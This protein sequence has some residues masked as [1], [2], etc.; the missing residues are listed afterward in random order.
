MRTTTAQ[1][2]DARRPPA[3]LPRALVMIVLTVFAAILAW[4][5]ASQLG[6]VAT[7]LVIAWFIAL[8]ME[9]PVRWLARRGM[10]RGL[11]TGL[12]MFGTILASL[13]I[14]TVFGQLFVAQ[15]VD[16]IQAVPQ[17]YGQ[18]TD[19]VLNAFGYE[20]PTTDK[21]LVQ[22]VE[23]WGSN[24]AEGVIGV[25]GT[26]LGALFV[27]SA[28]LLVVFYMVAQGP[29]FKAS[30]LSLLAP[31]RQREVLRV[32][33]A[34]QEQVSNFLSSRIL[35]AA[36]SALV[37]FVYLTVAHVPYAV[38]LAAFSGIVSQ[39]IPTIGTYIGGALPVIV[40]L[41]V[42]PLTGLGVVIF[43]VVYQQVENLLLAPKISAHTMELNPAVAF[44]SVL[45][46]GAVFGALGA[47]LALPVAATIKAV[48]GAYLH[49]HALVDS[50][51]LAETS[52]SRKRGAS[53]APDEAEDSD[54]GS[55]TSTGAPTTPTTAQDAE[56][57]AVATPS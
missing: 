37:T 20:L 26:I 41:T 30:I 29:R 39:F 57:G 23:G 21:V 13:G 51:L 36:V 19:F 7:I 54:S 40:G 31:D 53:P 46:F 27:L 9:P 25:G 12:V 38:P 3:W 33:D 5:A 45:A 22:L 34:S 56:P 8:A 11:A 50:D 49:R 16:L 24:V 17:L 43:I 55:A 18:L 32:W 1:R 42:S 44:V 14:L 2:V 6:T 52:G 47:F 15:L 28:V 48:S 10:R 35:L 4:R